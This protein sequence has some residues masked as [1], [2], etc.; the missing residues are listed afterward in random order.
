LVKAVNPDG[1]IN[2]NISSIKI[3]VATAWFKSWWF[4]ILIFVAVA[5]VIW[6]F[7]RNY[8]LRKL[9]KHKAKIEKQHAIEQERTRLARELHD[10]LGSML[11]GIK[12]SFSSIQNNIALDHHQN[13]NFNDNIEKLN[14][15]IREIRNI[16]HSMMDSDSLLEHGLPNALKDY[17]RNI[18]HPGSLD[19]SFKEIAQENIV[20]KEEQAFHILRIVQELIQN[21]IKHAFAKKALVQLSYDN[22]QL[23]IT[24]EDDGIGFD[25][26][27]LGGKRGIGLNNIKERIKILN[28]EIDI[29]SEKLQGTSVFISCPL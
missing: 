16:S 10:G 1:I 15:S 8:Y 7:I 28:G 6:Y 17:C 25:V 19:V 2:E 29:K 14:A 3:V 5:T 21:V 13:K 18:S 9:D 22:N 4:T 24:V 27:G 12:H 26:S 20:L 11:S 23:N